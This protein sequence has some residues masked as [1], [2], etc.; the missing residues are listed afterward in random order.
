MAEFPFFLRLNNLYCVLYYIFFIYLFVNGN[1]WGFHILATMNNAAMNMGV[2]MFLLISVF[3]FFRYIPRRGIA[4]PYGNSILNFPRNL[5]PFFHSVSTSSYFHQQCMRFFSTT[6]PI[7]M[8]CLVDNSHS[9]KCE[10]ASHCSFDLHF[11][12][13]YWSWASFHM[14][15]ATC[16][17]S[18]E[19]CLFRSCAHFLI[20]LFV[21]LLLRFVNSLCI[22]GINP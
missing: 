1:L 13:S 15:V 17:S 8:I 20:G 12:S 6:S 21:F 7:L 10:V 18:W 11:P 14:F 19:M 16:M 2:H 3:K 4:A 5:Q 22:L 9:N